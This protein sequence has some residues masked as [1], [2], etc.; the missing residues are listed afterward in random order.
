[1]VHFSDESK[2]SLFESDGKR[3]ARRKNGEHL[4]SQC[5]KKTKMWRGSVM[6]WGMISSARVGPIV[7]F[8]GNINGS[9]YKELLHQHSL[10]HFRRGTVETPIFMQ[11]NVPCRKAKTVKF[12]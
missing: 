5:V 3:F 9:F 7:R 1:M 8:H 10:P 2:F 6:V 11:D 12:S 4:S